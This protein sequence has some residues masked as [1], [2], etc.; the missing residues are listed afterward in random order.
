MEECLWRAVLRALTVPLTGDGK[1]EH[2]KVMRG[3]QGGNALLSP[4]YGLQDFMAWQT[5]REGVAWKKA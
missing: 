5:E 3:L 1:G 2:K 4:F